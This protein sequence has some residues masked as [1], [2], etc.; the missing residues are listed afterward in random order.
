MRVLT[1]VREMRNRYADLRLNSQELLKVELQC[2]LYKIK[3]SDFK[4]A[5]FFENFL[6]PHCIPIYKSKCV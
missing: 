1:F 2:V 3:I 5:H 6:I 4:L